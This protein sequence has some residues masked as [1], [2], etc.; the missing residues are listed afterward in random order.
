MEAVKGQPGPVMVG[1]IILLQ[2]Q[3]SVDHLMNIL[4]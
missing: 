1:M 4:N 2:M 3:V